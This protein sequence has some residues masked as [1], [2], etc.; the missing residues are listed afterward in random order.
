MA[1]IINRTD[2]M[3][4]RLNGDFQY[5]KSELTNRFSPDRGPKGFY[6]V[7]RQDGVSLVDSF[8]WSRSEFGQVSLVS[9]SIPYKVSELPRFADIVA[10]SLRPSLLVCT[11]D[12]AIKLW[13]YVTRNCGD[14]LYLLETPKG[15]QTNLYIAGIDGGVNIA[16]SLDHFPTPGVCAKINS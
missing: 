8:S 11:P 2:L 4:S 10:E 6:V 5:V 12:S 13:E 14:G 16:P 7:V 9:Q 15:K 1:E 3:Q